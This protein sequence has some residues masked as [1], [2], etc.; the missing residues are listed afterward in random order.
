MATRTGQIFGIRLTAIQRNNCISD[1]YAQ[2]QTLKNTIDELSKVTSNPN[3][4]SSSTSVQQPQQHLLDTVPCESVQ[5]TLQCL[6]DERDAKDTPQAQ[7][8]DDLSKKIKLEVTDFSGQCDAR[9]F[10]DWLISIEDYFTWFHIED[11]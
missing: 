4:E 7:C 1:L 2:V 10:L 8:Q 6:F 5:E 9:A 11:P 3:G